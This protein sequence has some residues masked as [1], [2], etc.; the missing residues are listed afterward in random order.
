[1]T[2][3]F[4]KIDSFTATEVYMCVSGCY[5]FLIFVPWSRCISVTTTL[6]EEKLMEAGPQLVRK[7]I[8]RITLKDIQELGLSS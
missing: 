2:I 7:D 3:Q 8:S 5:E 6:S 4:D 1:M